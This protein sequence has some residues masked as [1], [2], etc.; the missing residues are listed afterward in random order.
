MIAYLRSSLTN[1]RLV[2]AFV[3]F[4]SAF[5]LVSALIAEHVFGL[6]PCILCLY[7]R[8][9]FAINIVLGLAAFGCLLL[10]RPAIARA[11]LL[12]CGLSF[13]ACAVIAFYHTGVEQHWWASFLEAC[14][15]SF[16]NLDPET[17]LAKIESTQA[18]RCDEI[19]WQDPIIGLS[20]ANYNIAL[21]AVCAAICY[22]C[23][24]KKTQ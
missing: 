22:Y 19:P 4:I 16:D 23:V 21:S 13:T 6:Q 8:V 5:S 15:V 2:S 18:V 7:Q 24:F 20:M 10:P 11:F 9:P 3:V 17:L 12:L 14:T 1:A